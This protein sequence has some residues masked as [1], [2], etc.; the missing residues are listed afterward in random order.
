MLSW[1]TGGSIGFASAEREGSTFWIEFQS[2]DCAAAYLPPGAG[3][4]QPETGCRG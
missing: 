2:M 1:T 3:E 4:A